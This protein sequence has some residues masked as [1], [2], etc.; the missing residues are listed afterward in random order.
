MKQNVLAWIAV[1]VVSIV[2]LGYG[3]DRVTLKYFT[4]YSFELFFTMVLLTFLS[5]YKLSKVKSIEW[6]FRKILI[7][8]LG[9]RL[10]LFWATPNLSDDY[11]RFIWDGTLINNGINPFVFLPSEVIQWPNATELGFTQE[12]YNGFNSQQYYSVYP[13]VNQFIFF[14]SAYFGQGNVFV[15]ALVIRLCIVLAELGS[16]YFLGK[17]II[18]QNLP[19][20]HLLWYALNPL[21][22]LEFTVNLHFESLMV[23]FM[24]GALYYLVNQS[25]TK[26]GVFWALAICTKLLP[27]IYL[28]FLLKRYSVKQWLKVVSVALGVTILLFLP[29]WNPVIPNNIQDSLDKYFGYF[30]F[31]AGIPYLIRRIGYEFYDYSILFRVMP[32]IKKLFIGFVVLY[33]LS[34]FLFK[35]TSSIF[36]PIYYT[37]F[38]YFLLAGILHPWYI[39]F[40]IPLGILSK[41]YSGIVW[42]LLIFLSYSAYQ[43]S[44]YKESMW[45]IG[46]EFGCLFLFLIY[47]KSR[48]LQSKLKVPSL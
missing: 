46:I 6:D 4:P 14:L 23:M 3:V 34:A 1:F 21:I 39:T 35:K 42:S 5:V 10:L 8:G 20:K 30:E 15:S 9:V 43:T 38:I 13:P 37:A 18:H 24:L 48:W 36:T 28:T 12:L 41:N 26:S 7:F 16:L 22:L 25:Y 45:I 32:F 33:G 47:E 44:T 17:L 40:L 31:N 29:F 11:F 27:I 19:I 2:F